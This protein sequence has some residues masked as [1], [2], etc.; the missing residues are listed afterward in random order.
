MQDSVPEIILFVKH[1][2][3]FAKISKLAIDFSSGFG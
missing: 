2:V 1:K 3:Q